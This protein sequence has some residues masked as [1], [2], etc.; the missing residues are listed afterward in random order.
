ASAGFGARQRGAALVSRPPL[1]AS[2]C[3]VLAEGEG[4]EASR[5]SSRLRDF[6]SRALGQTMRPFQEAER[7]GFEPTR[8]IHPTAFRERHLQPLG[9]L[10]MSS[11]ERKE[12]RAL[13]RPCTSGRYA[14]RD[15]NPRPFGPQPNALSTELRAHIPLVAAWANPLAA[16]IRIA[17]K[18]ERVQAGDLAPRRGPHC[19]PRAAPVR[20]LTR[21]PSSNRRERAGCGCWADGGRASMTSRTRNRG[22]R[23]VDDRGERAPSR[24]HS[25]LFVA[26][27]VTISAVLVI[28]LIEVVVLDLF[29]S[30]GSDADDFLQP[31]IAVTPGA[32]EAEMRTR[33]QENPDD[34]NAML[35]LAD[36][37]ANTGRASEAVQW[38]E[39]AVQARPDDVGLRV[40]LGRT[41]MQGGYRLDA[42]IQFKK[43]IELAPT[44]PEPIF[45]LGQ[46][47]QESD[48]P[49]ESEAR[50]Q[51][52]RVIEVAPDSVYAER[53]QE[54]LDALDRAS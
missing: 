26:L 36:L 3:G 38:Y 10:S 41:L 45:L 11:P 12:C 13:V 29:T 24:R 39:K 42:E 40:A 47:Y 49:R 43:A 32:Q 48:P 25:R 1:P 27:A 9:H 33:L 16:C 7:V 31:Q 34:V 28:T 30:R 19:W 8:A 51:Y 4:F 14:R 52:E 54:Q 22:R 23:P 53:A 21:S 17:H 18:G 46:L 35:V 15:L 50:A 20:I 44:N 2:R 6:Q 5:R 37:L